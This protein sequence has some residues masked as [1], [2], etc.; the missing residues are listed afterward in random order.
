[1]PQIQIVI[2][3]RE[4]EVAC[5]EGEEHYLQGA[6][7]M[8]D[9]EAATLAAQMGRLPEQT[10]LLMAGLMLAD[11]TAD[12]AERLRR[13]ESRIAAL[14]NRAAPPPQRIEVPVIPTALCESLAE[15]AARAEAIAERVETGGQVEGR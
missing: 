15:M 10:M 11:K 8:L 5:Q 4:F 9:A 12:Y 1:M 2:G 14:E 13:A 3:G 6:A 7:A